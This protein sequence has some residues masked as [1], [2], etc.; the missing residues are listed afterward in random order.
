M[1][2]QKVRSLAREEA[3]DALIDVI[4]CTD[5]VSRADVR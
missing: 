4:V 5:I 2:V 1:A 3:K